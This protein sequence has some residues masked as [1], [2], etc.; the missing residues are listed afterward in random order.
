MDTHTKTENYQDGSSAA[1]SD[2]IKTPAI[3]YDARIARKKLDLLAGLKRRHTFKLFYSIKSASFLPLL[4]EMSGYVDGF[5]SSSL[6]ESRLIREEF[7]HSKL[8]HYT[9]PGIR[10]HEIQELA[11]LCNQISFNSISQLKS[12]GS[13]VKF[14]CD[15]LIRINPQ[16]NF[17][18]DE[19]YDPC[20]RH[21][22]LG[23]K[24]E[25]FKTLISNQDPELENLKGL[26]IHN[27]CESIDSNEMYLT[28]EKLCN[29]LGEWMS[30]TGM[31]NLGGGY[32]FQQQSDLKGL[33][34]T[35]SRLNDSYD[36]EIVI[37]PGKT[38]VNEAGELWTTVV[39]IFKSDDKDVAVLDTSV[40]HLPEIFE[41][42][43]RPDVMT[44]NQQGT[45]QYRL[46]GC[47][48]LSGDIFGDYRFSEPL[49]VGSQIRFRNVGAYMYV[50]ASYFNGINLPN[51]YLI[52]KAGDMS[53]IKSS[54]YDDYKRQ[55]G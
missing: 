49:S 43:R 6:F 39:D 5:S 11:R 32:L 31:I 16:T 45:F 28:V 46:A 30:E 21:S 9:G 55:L 4:R 12:T 8:I 17:S 34:R 22:K 18:L 1:F 20:R 14:D 54:S 37:E 44:E 13:H 52:D 24:L 29:T 51:V 25:A 10:E 36:L 19:R 3:I 27:N 47:S 26:H 48:C 2:M 50:K 35:L 41:Y 33:I 53:L 38:I 42:Q 23:V 15:K 40:N 7:G